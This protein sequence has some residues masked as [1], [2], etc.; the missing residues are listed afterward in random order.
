MHTHEVLR[1]L[2]DAIALLPLRQRQ[3]VIWRYYEGRSFESIAE[4]LEIQAAT[5]RSLLRHG[6]NN[7][8]R[9]LTG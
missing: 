3:V 8:R 1:Q 6:V 2:P 5:V 7:L 4:T 9:T